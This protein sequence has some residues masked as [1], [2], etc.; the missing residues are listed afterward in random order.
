[1]E[2]HRLTHTCALFPHAEAVFQDDSGERRIAFPQ[3]A[4]DAQALAARLRAAGVPRGGIVGVQARNDYEWLLLDLAV[5]EVGA[6]LLAFPEDQPLDIA[7]EARRH[8]L[9]LFATDR[10]RAPRM[11]PWIVELAALSRGAPAPGSARA[12]EVEPPDPDLLT[13]TFSSGTSGYLKGLDISRRGTEVL[14]DEFVQAY[15]LGDHDRLAVFL[16]FSNYQ[17]RMLAYACLWR[18]ASLLVTPVMRVVRELRGFRPTLLVAPPAFYDQLVKLFF[19]G[20]DPGTAL[21]EALGGEAR[22]LL[23][24]MAPVPRRLLE[25]YARSGL[26]MFEVYGV[27]EAGMIAWNTIVRCRPGTLGQPLPSAQVRLGADGEIIVRKQAPLA[28]GYF[29]CRPGDAEKTFPAPQTVATGDLGAFD[30]DGYLRFLGRSKEVLVTAAGRKFSPTEIEQRLDAIDG[31]Q[32]ST[33][34]MLGD[35]APLVVGIFSV[36]SMPPQRAATLREEIDRINRT[37]EPYQRLNRIIISDLVFSAENGLLTRNLKR[38]RAAIARHFRSAVEDGRVLD[39]HDDA[40]A[41]SPLP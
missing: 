33:L 21:R 36:R 17:Q 18:G 34:V 10:P 12:T 23:T 3:L 29:E 31:V 11:P 22:A 6:V 41:P 19:R 14:I 2:L 15:G 27:V 40:A 13:R 16:P 26:P 32:T 30:D 38:D 8:R 1:M 24:G 28:R 9:C 20:Q 35:D 37:L 7:A 39:L 5:L 4:L 25:V